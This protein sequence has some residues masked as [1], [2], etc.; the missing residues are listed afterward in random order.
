MSQVYIDAR[1]HGPP[2]S[3]NGGYVC[4]AVAELAEGP[5]TVSLRVPP[6]LE[7]SMS[8]RTE[9]DGR[10]RMFDGDTMVAEAVPSGRVALAVPA[11]VDL[12][13]AQDAAKRFT[14][15][16]EH[17]F[18]TC[19]TCGPLRPAGDGLR[20]FTGAVDGQGSEDDL[21]AAPWTPDADVDAGDGTVLAPHVWAALD[22]PSYF[23]AVRDEPAL[24]AR[25][26][27]DLR[28][29]VHVGQPYVVL[30]WTAA[31]ADG[32]KRHGGSA[33]LD[34][35]GEVVAVAESLWVTLSDEALAALLD[36]A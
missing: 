11:V 29:P 36:P 14:G 33:I 3:A 12:T 19:W 2:R 20:I 31:A 10:L 7:R 24:L 27:A 16:D 9:D 28:G 18:P 34:T 32:R 25:L 30:G 4:G 6:P 15:F 8:V 23:G 5:V 26:T 17:P 21:V 22:C 35:D 1:F 13:S